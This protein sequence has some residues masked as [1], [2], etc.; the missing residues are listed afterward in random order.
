[1][2]IRGVLHG[3]AAAPPVMRKQGHG[4]FVNVSSTA[5]HTIYATAAVYSAT[6]VAVIAI[7]EALR[8]ENDTIRIT[9]ISPGVTESE[10]ADS[11]S[12]AGAREAVKKFR[13]VAI[14]AEAIA[15]AIDSPSRNP[16]MSML[17][18]SSSDPLRTLIE[19]LEGFDHL[20]DS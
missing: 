17:V 3:I 2:N 13:R 9:V 15:R 18:K 1:V 12:D 19:F 14:P 16:R 6:K 7:S 20:S 8:Q 4:Q 11:I 10:L 5:G